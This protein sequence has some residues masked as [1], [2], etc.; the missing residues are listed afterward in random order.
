MIQRYEIDATEMGGTERT[1]STSGYWV[2]YEDHQRIVDEAV[3]QLDDLSN[4]IYELKKEN[5][6][7]LALRT[8]PRTSS[9]WRGAG[10]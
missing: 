8:R 4:R 7:L 6:W 1:E 3:R 2:T 9:L 10:G 5:E